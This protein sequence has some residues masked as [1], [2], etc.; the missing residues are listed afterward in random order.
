MFN[1][2]NSAVV[3]AVSVVLFYLYKTETD[4]K[5][6]SAV[7]YVFRDIN[8]CELF[9]VVTQPDTVSSWFRW[10]KH[11]RSADEKPLG[12]GKLYQ[13]YYDSE[14]PVI[15]Q[16]VHYEPCTVIV[17]ESDCLLKP[18]I[19]LRTMYVT[20]RKTK[21][22]ISIQFRRA[23]ALFQISLGE[24][25][26]KGPFNPGTCIAA[27]SGRDDSLYIKMRRAI[28]KSFRNIKSLLLL[29]IA[30]ASMVIHRFKVLKS[31]FQHST[32]YARN[33]LVSEMTAVHSTKD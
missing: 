12:I 16:V 28:P 14:Q 8:R 4:I 29:A 3:F 23:S 1:K 32:S 5:S 13:A 17:L 33:T 19:E 31:T 11:F 20:K 7:S 15:F 2:I 24:D 27:G 6:V 22:L 30:V 26:K 10:V 9:Y 21:L 18:R 25:D